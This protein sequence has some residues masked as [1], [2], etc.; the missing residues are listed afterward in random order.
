VNA[1]ETFHLFP[2]FL[3]FVIMPI[4][5]IKFTL[6]TAC[7]ALSIGACGGVQ[8]VPISSSP[9]S[10]VPP[11][12]TLASNENAT[13][14]TIRFLEGKV[15]ND[16]EDFG[17]NNKLAG[18]YLLRLR[19]TGD[20]AYLDLTFRAARAS[21][22]SV[23]DVR[24]S[25]GLAAL[26]QAEF[27]A[28]EFAAAR[29]HARRL[30]ELEPRKSY[31]QA[32]LGDA[33]LELGDYDEAAA[34]FK[35]IAFIDGGIGYNS[36]IKKARLAQLR[37]DNADAQKNFSDAL[38]FALNASVP[39]RETVAWL[40][41]QLGETAFSVGDYERAEKH[42]RDSLVTF[43]DYYRAIA[44]LGR[45]L[46]ARGDL[47][48]AIEQYENAVRIIPDPNYVAALGDLYK[49]AGREDDAKRQYELVEQIG[50]LSVLNGALYNRQL[51]L[52][53]ADHDIKTEEAY[54]LAAQEYE[55]RKDI[56]GADALAWT[57]LKADKLTEAQTAIK[58][59]LRLGT[60]DAKLFYH[61]GMIEK[62]LGNKAEA[63]GYLQ[64]ALKINPAFDPL[65]AEKAR[66]ALRELQ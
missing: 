46:A 41:W 36:E 45:T 24:N 61:A 47:P 56:Y 15:K 48:G 63:V 10:D 6:L 33:L 19:E 7:A 29:D 49:L 18:L 64:N 66:A 13:E 53:Y 2:R 12:V 11:A 14:N 28:H 22:A 34:A 17:A 59:A 55:E 38:V 44:S 40:R 60:Q 20:T 42:Y 5:K 65:Q 43:P 8:S 25:G 16:P 27:A 58:D 23:P 52:F 62:G 26:A 39:P 31:P 50:R 35:K 3:K 30:I 9:A 4:R 1:F 51:A 57:G 32:M 37:G 54:R 21:L